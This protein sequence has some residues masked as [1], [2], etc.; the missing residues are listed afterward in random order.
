MSNLLAALNVSTGALKAFD[1]ALETIQNNVAN[2]QTPGYAAQTQTLDSMTFDASNGE[3]S[4]SHI[5]GFGN[6][7]CAERAL[8]RLLRLGRVTQ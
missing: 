2:S 3:E 5:G 4:L 8:F 6:R 1:L 7:Q